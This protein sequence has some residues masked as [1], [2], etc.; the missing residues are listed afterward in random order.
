MLATFVS[1]QMG[2]T[3]LRDPD[4]YK[5]RVYQTIS[6]GTVNTMRCFKQKPPTK[7]AAAYMKGTD[8][9]EILKITNQHNHGAE[10]LKTEV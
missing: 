5:Y 1:S 2:T 6:D 4:G 8:P 10:A 3:L 7:H 9:Q